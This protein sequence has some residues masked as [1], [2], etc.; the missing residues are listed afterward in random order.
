MAT[1]PHRRTVKPRTDRRR[2]ACSRGWPEES[3]LPSFSSMLRP[4]TDP[5]EKLSPSSGKNLTRVTIDHV[6]LTRRKD[7]RQWSEVPTFDINLTMQ[8]SADTA[9]SGRRYACADD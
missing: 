6:V 5:V 9:A 3:G 7:K 1:V 4:P 2:A 8:C